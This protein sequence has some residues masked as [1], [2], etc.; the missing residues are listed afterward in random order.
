MLQ[1][2]AGLYLNF[3]LGD[4]DVDNGTFYEKS[5]IEYDNPLFGLMVG[6][7]LGFRV[8]RGYFFADFRYTSNL[9][10][11]NI[12]DG[13][14]KYHRSAFMIYLGYQYYLKGKQ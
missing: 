10:D 3:G 11:T 12:E 6:G 9:G 13:W 4:L 2:Q 5:G 1:P 7:A 8:G 14:D